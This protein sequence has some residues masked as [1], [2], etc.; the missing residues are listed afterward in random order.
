MA[1]MNQG[2]KLGVVERL[3]TFNTKKRDLYQT[4]QFKISIY[5]SIAQIDV[6]IFNALF[7]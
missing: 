2:G 5:C 1:R 6:C 7:S 4:F 3:L